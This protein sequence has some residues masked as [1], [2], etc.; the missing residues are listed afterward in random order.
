MYIKWRIFSV[1]NWRF[2][3]RKIICGEWLF[4]VKFL[5]FDS[6]FWHFSNYKKLRFLLLI[7]NWKWYFY[8]VLKYSLLSQVAWKWD[9]YLA[10]F[11]FYDTYFIFF[12]IPLIT[13]ISQGLLIRNF[14]YTI[15]IM[16]NQLRMLILI[17]LRVLYCVKIE[18]GFPKVLP[19][20]IWNYWNRVNKIWTFNIKDTNIQVHHAFL[21]FKFPQPFAKLERTFPRRLFRQIEHITYTHYMSIKQSITKL[22][23]FIVWKWT[24]SLEFRRFLVSYKCEKQVRDLI[25][26]LFTQFLKTLE[27]RLVFGQLIKSSCEFDIYWSLYEKTD[28]E[29]H[30]SLYT[31]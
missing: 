29:V 4:R 31:K 17:N 8:R 13:Y 9:L 27:S 19:E 25:F 22:I 24:Y 1:H 6:I 18:E 7:I 28:R 23:P 15:N 21:F 20:L 16:L 30:L 12:S 3:L 5:V 2:I 26:A 14:Q 11:Y 10:I